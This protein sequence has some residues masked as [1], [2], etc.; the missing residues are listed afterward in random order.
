MSAP[1]TS[2]RLLRMYPSRW[3]ERYGEELEGLIVEASGSERVPWRTRLD[4]AVSGVR[5]RKR[6]AGLGG[7]TPADRVRGGALLVLCAWA[8]FVVGGMIVGKFSEHWQGAVP[9]GSGGVAGTAFAVLLGGASLATALVLAGAVCA[10]PALLR[11][12]RRGG[13]SRI[14]GPVLGSLAVTAAA[15]AATVGLALWAGGL[16]AHQREG[17]DTAYAVAFVAWALLVCATFAAWAALAVRI[18]RLVEL[19]TA[20]LRLEARLCAA[21]AATMAVIGAAT[22]VW[23]V[24]LADAAPAFLTGAPADRGG[25]TLAPQLL[26]A[27]AVMTVATLLGARGASRAVRELPALAGTAKHR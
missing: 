1:R 3:R 21:V 11:F 12:L 14:R 23:W 27:V 15:I 18:A 20:V 24:S 16:D 13:W 6:A 7:G 10:A 4:V 22:I 17:G 8:L 2:A 19:P 5:E 25:S 26:V 9:A